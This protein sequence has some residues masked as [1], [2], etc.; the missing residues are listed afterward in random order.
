M[1]ITLSFRVCPVGRADCWV[2]PGATILG[3]ALQADKRRVVAIRNDWTRAMDRP[4]QSRPDPRETSDKGAQ[5]P[6]RQTSFAVGCA[7]RPTHAG[8]QECHSRARQ[9]VAAVP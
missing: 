7:Y 5:R 3:G 4:A 1:L 9:T 2:A 6:A 8:L